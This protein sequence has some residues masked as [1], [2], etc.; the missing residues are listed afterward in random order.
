MRGVLREA[1]YSADGLVAA[2]GHAEPPS[3]HLRTLPWLLD[4]TGEESQF[5]TLVRLF[6]MNV[7]VPRETLERTLPAWF[8]DLCRDHG[9]VSED[10]GETRATMLINAEREFL[11]ASDPYRR[12]LSPE[13]LDHVLTVNPTSVHLAQFALR[14]PVATTLDLA[15]GGGIQALFAADSSTEVL[16]TDLNER[17]VAYARFNARLNGLENIRCVVG[18]GFAA[19]EGR[20]FDRILCNPPFVLAPALE[21]LYRDSGMELDLFCQGLVAE[22]PAHLNEGGC[23]QMIFEWVQREDDPDWQTPLR[24]WFDGSGCDVWVIKEYTDSPEDYTQLRLREVI[25]DGPDAEAELFLRWVE[26]LRQRRVKTINGGL[27]LMRRRSGPTWTRFEALTEPTDGPFNAAVAGALVRFD[28]LAAHESDD[29]LLAARLR[30]SP[31][32][33]VDQRYAVSDRDWRSER[34]RLR[35]MAGV[36]RSVKLAADMANFLAQL[37]G[38]R[39]L[40]EAAEAL[41]KETGNDPAHVRGEVVRVV[42]DFME[43]GFIL[44]EDTEAPA[45]G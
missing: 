11:I 35:L 3:P 17:A 31:E 40:G 4:R 25:A 15:A 16:A 33:R 44:P 27:V 5:H 2:F 24:T 42:R 45:E 21:Y 7:A 1:N 43:L 6:F 8:A 38:S 13:R 22:A 34:I 29:S 30:L 14:T 23:F 12:M 28:F 36:P 10:A 39:T 18:D 9:M 20:T 19:A 41:A 26:S 32:A 37:D